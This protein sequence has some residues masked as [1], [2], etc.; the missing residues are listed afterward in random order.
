M[1]RFSFALV[2]ALC[3]SSFSYGAEWLKSFGTV[4]GSLTSSVK[5]YV[6]PTPQAGQVTGTGNYFWGGVRTGA[7]RVKQG[8]GATASTV[9][10]GDEFLTFC[11]SP[12]EELGSPNN[13][14]RIDTPTLY[15]GTSATNTDFDR[16]ARLV[17]F[18]WTSAVET[19]AVFGA[20]FQLALWS[21]IQDTAPNSLYNYSANLLTSNAAVNTEYNNFLNIA[22]GTSSF[23]TAAGSMMMYRPTNLTDSQILIAKVVG[24]GNSSTPVPEPFTIGIGLAAAGA[25]VQRRLKSSS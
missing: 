9:S 10:Y 23:G 7:I 6:S 20:A 13:P 4:S 16:I 14:W 3:L 18:G 15:T 19:N 17:S 2:G 8:T 12:F 24:G 11:I 25:F 22:N 5:G 1:K 21:I